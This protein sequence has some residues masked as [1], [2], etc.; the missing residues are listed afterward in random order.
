MWQKKNAEIFNNAIWR[1]F[2]FFL[3]LCD[4]IF[5]FHII[6]KKH[7]GIDGGSFNNSKLLSCLSSDTNETC[8]QYETKK[9][10]VK[11]LQNPYNLNE[12]TERD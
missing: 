7:F 10:I 9:K 1:V 11:V 6:G 3:S 8:S 5:T 2:W 12:I 4:S